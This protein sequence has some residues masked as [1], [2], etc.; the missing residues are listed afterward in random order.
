MEQ[1][2]SHPTPFTIILIY[3]AGTL[4][5][6]GPC[7]LSLL[8]IT[9][10]YIGGTNNKNNNN[11]KILSFCGGIVLALVFLGA[12][13]GL[14][15]RIYGQLPDFFNIFIAIF[16]IVMGLNLLGILKF[17]LPNTPSLN[18]LE[19]KVPPYIAPLIAGTTFG[20]A[21]S[22]CIT[23]VLATLLAWVSQAQ[24]P[25]I[26]IIFLFFF[27]LGQVTPLIIVGIT[28]EN[29]KKVLEFRKYS[30]VIPYASGIVLISIGVINII[31]N[32]I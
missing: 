22:P 6:L 8:P 13:S 20:L 29:M 23:P 11:L 21:S 4:T 12:V 25:L 30:Q 1:G 26:S 7:S 32:W 3:C 18:F 16:A 31:S 15:G 2:V 9:V 14:L 17:Q 19:E 10:A 24:N 28:T 5:S 27:G